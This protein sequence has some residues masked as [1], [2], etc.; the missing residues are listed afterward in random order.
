MPSSAA[1]YLARKCTRVA[2]LTVPVTVGGVTVRG[3][4]ATAERVVE[5]GV[6]QV[7]ERSEVLTMRAG[8]VS[9][10]TRGTVLV[11]DGV[12]R[13]VRDRLLNTEGA[14]VELILAGV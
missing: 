8:E 11:V 7:V 6:G 9:S 10:V 2:P 4:L 1:D 5:D 12:S 3:S 13:V 14:M